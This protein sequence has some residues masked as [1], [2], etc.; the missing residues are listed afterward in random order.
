MRQNRFLR[1]LRAIYNKISSR[2]KAGAVDVLKGNA[3]LVPMEYRKRRNAR[4]YI[5]RVNADGNG[6]CVT[7]PRGGSMAEAR[8]FAKRN[9]RWLEDR[10]RRLQEAKTETSEDT[11]W[12]RGEE[13]SRAALEAHRLLNEFI[14]PGRRRRRTGARG[15]SGRC[16]NWHGKSCPCAWANW[17]RRMD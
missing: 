2:L 15:S 14:F 13:I 3:G 4:R 10:L 12:F 9:L 8:S 16:G 6:G 17:R 7:I 5:L 1:M 11:I